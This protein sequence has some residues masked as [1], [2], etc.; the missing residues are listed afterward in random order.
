MRAMRSA[1]GIVD[2]KITET[3]QLRCKSII[4]LLFLCV[5]AQILKQQHIAVFEGIGFRL[6]LI[7]DAIISKLNRPAKQ[8]R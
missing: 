3:R 2:V 6:H 7:P 1:E 5:K 4:V 8:I